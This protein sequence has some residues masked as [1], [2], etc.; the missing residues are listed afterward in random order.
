MKAVQKMLLLALD[1]D[2]V[3]PEGVSVRFSHRELR[4]IVQ[5][6]GLVPHRTKSAIA[7]QI[8]ERWRTAVASMGEQGAHDLLDQIAVT[9]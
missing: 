2:A 4:T 5:T 9:P 3:G 1:I 8:C 6:L 7:R